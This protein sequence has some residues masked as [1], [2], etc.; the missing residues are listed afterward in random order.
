MKTLALIAVLGSLMGCGEVQ[1][2]RLCVLPQ[3]FILKSSSGAPLE[4]L[5]VTVKPL[6]SSSQE[7]E[8]RFECGGEVTCADD[9]ITFPVTPGLEGRPLRVEAVTGEVFEGTYTPTP[10]EGST[11]GCGCTGQMVDQTLTLN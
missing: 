2:T 8:E 1:C 11:S 6:G 4:P 3:T 7:Q 5:R 9:R 10:A